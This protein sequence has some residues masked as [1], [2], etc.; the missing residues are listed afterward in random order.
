MPSSN[1]HPAD[2]SGPDLTTPATRGTYVYN[3]AESSIGTIQTVRNVE[4][5]GSL[6]LTDYVF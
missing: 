2:G 1:T 6:D 3:L 5:G 4:T